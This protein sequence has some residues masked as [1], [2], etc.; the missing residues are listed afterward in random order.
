VPYI[1]IMI[2]RSKDCDKIQ[3]HGVHTART[4]YQSEIVLFQIYETILLITVILFE[5]LSWMRVKEKYFVYTED[6]S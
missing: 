3:T 2:L 5:S 1:K 4:P 6:I